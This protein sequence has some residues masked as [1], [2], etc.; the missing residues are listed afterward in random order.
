MI[1]RPPRS[2]LLPYTTLF[3]SWRAGGLHS[4][5]GLEDL[6]RV[7]RTPGDRPGVAGLQD[8]NRAF[9]VQLRPAAQN[10][11]HRLVVAPGLGLGLPR[12]LS[13]PQTHRDRLARGEV[14]LPHLAPRR[15]SGANLSDVVLGHVSLPES[16]SLR[17]YSTRLAR[18]LPANRLTIRLAA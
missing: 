17:S 2:T 4:G 1:R 3:R 7:P 12:L 6:V 15:L 5:K 8:D 18:G 14:P 16:A 11:A 13:V 9:E 10:V